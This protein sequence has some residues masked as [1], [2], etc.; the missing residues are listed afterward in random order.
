MAFRYFSYLLLLFYLI[1]SVEIDQIIMQSLKL[2]FMF[3]HIENT[4]THTLDVMID[5]AAR[6]NALNGGR[7]RVNFIN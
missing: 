1:F 7:A 6:L 2:Y 4:H 5:T 3:D